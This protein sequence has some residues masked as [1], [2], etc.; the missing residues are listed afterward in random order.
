MSDNTTIGRRVIALQQLAMDLNKA[1][2]ELV[3]HPDN[4]GPD[5]QAMDCYKQILEELALV[6]D[7]IIETRLLLWRHVYN[8]ELQ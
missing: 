8:G 4:T 3:E 5:S 6:N 1:A 2:I 7:S